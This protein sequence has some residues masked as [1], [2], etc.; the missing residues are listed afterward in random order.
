MPCRL[1]CRSC[2]GHTAN[3]LQHESTGHTDSLC[4]AF[5]TLYLDSRGHSINFTRLKSAPL[6]TLWILL[7]AEGSRSKTP[8]LFQESKHL[9]GAS[10]THIRGVPRWLLTRQFLFSIFL[11]QQLLR[12][13]LTNT[14]KYTLIFH[15]SFIYKV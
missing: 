8:Y 13:C 1:C 6:Y 4:S 2:Y 10:C 9:F 11:F 15:Y 12:P 7:P 3:L 5:C 14:G